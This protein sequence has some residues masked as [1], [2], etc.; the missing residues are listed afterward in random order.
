MYIQFNCTASYPGVRP[1]RG[2]VLK[3]VLGLYQC[4]E[5]TKGQGPNSEGTELKIRFVMVTVIEVTV[6]MV[7][8]VDLHMITLC[9]HIQK[10][11]PLVNE[12]GHIHFK[13]P[14]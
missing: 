8:N 3:Q 9:L 2:E 5:Q 10:L 7:Q 6:I 13:L 1:I 11:I 12:L 4:Q 14:L